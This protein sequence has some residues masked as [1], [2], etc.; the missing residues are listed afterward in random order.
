LT[1]SREINVCTGMCCLCLGVPRLT[2]SCV[3]EIEVLDINDH[4]PQISVS[5]VTSSSD[6]HVTE[7]ADPGTFVALVSVSDA[8]LSDNARTNCQL[9]SRGIV[10]DAVENNSQFNFSSDM[11]L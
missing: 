9:Q 8:D 5:T 2:G 10:S 1:V 3:V 4:A 11:E 6:C 7:S